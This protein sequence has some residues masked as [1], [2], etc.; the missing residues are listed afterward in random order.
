MAE[1][2]YILENKFTPEQVDLIDC[3]IRGMYLA[4]RSEDHAAQNGCYG[5]F[6]D[7][8]TRLFKEVYGDAI[9][10]ALYNRY[11]FDSSTGG[12][13]IHWFDH[14]V[15]TDRGS[16]DTILNDCPAVTIK[17]IG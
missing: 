15:E 11:E 13:F 3:A 17:G 4:N 8:L 7:A 6:S 14:I 10:E 2:I 16:A 9:G 12:E 5:G 1:Y